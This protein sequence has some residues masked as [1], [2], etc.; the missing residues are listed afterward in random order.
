MMRNLRLDQNFRP[1]SF[2]NR[3]A[4]LLIS[5]LA[6]G[7]AAVNLPAIAESPARSSVQ[8]SAISAPVANLPNG[9]YL[10]G[11][12]PQ[13]EQIGQGYFVFEVNQGKVVGALYMPRS[14]FDCASGSFKQNQLA[15]TVVNSYDRST[16]PF[17][18]ALE[19]GS[20]VASTGGSAEKVSLQGFHR[21]SE[22]SA[23]DYRM[24]NTCKADLQ[25]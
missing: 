16:N 1:G 3:Y 19:T 5:T 15:L 2:L 20:T 13:P 12:S 4:R 25:K 18:I 14:S 7:I 6:V 23:N 22:I 11:Q 21:I 10:Y 8:V 24:L 17:D 9:V